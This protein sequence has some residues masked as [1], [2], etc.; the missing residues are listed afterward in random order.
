M[1][2][3]CTRMYLDSIF[4]R[5]WLSLRISVQRPSSLVC[6]GKSRAQKACCYTPVG[7][8]CQFRFCCCN[9]TSWLSRQESSPLHSAVCSKVIV[10]KY[11]WVLAAVSKA[12]P[13]LPGA[14]ACTLGS[15]LL[16]HLPHLLS[17]PL[18]CRNNAF[19]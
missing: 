18:F 14:S 4:L 16:S 3:K 10:Q 19:Y 11:M 9:K 17:R 12:S 2:L 5:K 1:E 7:V 15:S 8:M 13:Q 6:L